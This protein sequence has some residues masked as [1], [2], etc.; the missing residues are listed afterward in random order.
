M[1]YGTNQDANARDSSN[2]Y[3]FK[4]VEVS[5]ISKFYKTYTNHVSLG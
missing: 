2:P 3:D 5:F 1:E 4:G